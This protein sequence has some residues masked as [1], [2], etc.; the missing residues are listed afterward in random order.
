MVNSNQGSNRWQFFSLWLDIH[1]W[2]NN[3][4]P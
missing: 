1:S 3:N 4:V 2:R